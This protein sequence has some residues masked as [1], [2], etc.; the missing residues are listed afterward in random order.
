[1][2]IA[3]AFSIESA[4]LGDPACQQTVM[5]ALELASQL[6]ARDQR[7]R[8]PYINHY[9]DLRIMPTWRR[10]LLVAAV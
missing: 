9:A 10:E 8:E 1:M 4:H 2:G 6:H 5:R 7:Q 3:A